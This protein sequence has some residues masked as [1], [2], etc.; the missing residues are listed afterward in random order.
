M[1]VF[2]P[3]QKNSSIVKLKKH[4]WSDDFPFLHI[5]GFLLHNILYIAALQQ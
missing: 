2:L 4:S 5:Y 3:H 1:A